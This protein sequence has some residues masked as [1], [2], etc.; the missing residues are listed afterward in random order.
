MGTL[1]VAEGPPL[2]SGAARVSADDDALTGRHGR[3]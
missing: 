2:A 3:L 1:A